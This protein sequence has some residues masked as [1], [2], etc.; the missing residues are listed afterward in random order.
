MSPPSHYIEEAED[1]LPRLAP[2]PGMTL[3]ELGSGGGSLASHLLPHFALTLT[4]ISPGM[5]RVSE[6]VTPGAEHI[7]GDMRTLRLG[8]QFDRVLIHDAIM[9]MTTEDDLR[10]ALAT[11]RHH[12]RPEGRVIVLPD[13]VAE[14]FEAE[15]SHGGEDG[16][17][18][19]GLRYLEWSWDPDP[20]DT[21]HDVAYALILREADGRLRTELDHQVEGLF[22]RAT[23]LRLFSEAG[24]DARTE[25]DPWRQDIFIATRSNQM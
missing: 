8:R 16:A 2:E 25:K 23:W 19:R 17:D 20:A 3:L 24:L 4:D 12:L 7:R 18:G 6:R 1:L 22:P 21:T 15:T 10:A 14:T 5:S 13:C 9:Y 11:A